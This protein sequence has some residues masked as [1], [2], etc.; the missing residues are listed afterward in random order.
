M[1]SGKKFGRPHYKRRCCVS[2]CKKVSSQF[3]EDTK[4]VWRNKVY[5]C[6]F[7]NNVGTY[8]LRR[9]LLKNKSQGEFILLDGRQKI[10]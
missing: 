7:H 4:I 6:R 8:Q 5:L 2:G 1:V 3:Y 10:L 9:S